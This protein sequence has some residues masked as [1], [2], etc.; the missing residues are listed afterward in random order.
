MCAPRET[1]KG[2]LNRC[3]RGRARKRLAALLG[4]GKEAGAGAARWS[5]PCRERLEGQVEGG[6]GG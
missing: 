3:R 6:A 5:A 2:F 4:P 1:R